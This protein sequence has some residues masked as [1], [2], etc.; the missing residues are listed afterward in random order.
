MLYDGAKRLV[1]PLRGCEAPEEE[2]CMDIERHD[3]DLNVEEP[4]VRLGAAERHQASLHRF[5]GGGGG[6]G[7]GMA[8]QKR[9]EDTDATMLQEQTLRG[10]CITALGALEAER[11]GGVEAYFRLAESQRQKPGTYC[12]TIASEDLWARD[13]EGG[14]IIMV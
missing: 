11:H 7:R 5:W 3:G 6:N 13:V 2:M 9:G 10:D 4:S 1:S 8:Q 14:D 12:G